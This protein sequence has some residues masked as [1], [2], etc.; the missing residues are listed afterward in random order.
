MATATA[1][2]ARGARRDY[3]R[4]RSSRKKNE[5][6]S[7]SELVGF[8]GR[9]IYQSLNDE[10]GDISSTRQENLN[11]YIGAE[12]GTERE[13]YSK[14][15]TRETL[16]TVEW[17]LPSILRVFLSGDQIVS[18]DPVL[19]EDEPAA[20]Q[21]TDI[22]NHQILKANNGQGFLALHH[23]IKDALMYPN[24]YIK[25]YVEDCVKTDVGMVTGVTEMGVQMLSDDPDVTILEQ[26]SRQ[27]LVQ[28]PP[29]P[30]MP[31][32]GGAQPVTVYDLK[33]RTTKQIR[34]LRL[35][36][37]PPEECLVDNDLTTLDLDAADFVCHRRQRSFTDLVEAGYDP[38][39]LNMV[40][41]GDNY[42]WNDERVNRLFYTDENPDSADE[43]DRGMRMFWV[44]ECYVRVDYDGDELSERRKIT[45]IGNRIFDN[46][47]TNYQ[48]MIALASILMQH[49][50]TGMSYVDIV[51][52]LQLLISILTRQVLDN[53]YKIN[54]GKKVFSEDALTEDGAT[55][56]ALL[57][58]QAEFIPVRGAA[59]M[60]FAP[61]P[62]TS[63]VGEILP[64]I[65][66]FEQQRVT[67]T[68]VTPESTLDA[69]S[70]QEV[71]QDVFANAMDRASQRIEMLVRIFAETGFRKLMLKV[72]Q[73][74]R[75]HWD[76]AKTV[77]IRGTWIDVD[78]QGWRD[79]T[80]MT[81]STGLGFATKHQTLSMLVQMLSMQKE[82]AGSGLSN[83]QKIYNALDDLVAK[84]GLGDVRNFF[85]DPS[86]P[87]Y[88]PPEPPPDPNLILAQAQ[89][90]ALQ[91][92]Q[93]RKAQEFQVTAQIDSTKAQLDA[94][95]KQADIQLKQA[96]QQ[97]KLRELALREKE[98][99][100]EGTLKEGELAARVDNILADTQLKRAQADKTMVD[101]AA[102]AV[103]ASD[104]YQQALDVVKNAGELNNGDIEGS[105]N[106]E[107]G[108]E[109][110][111]ETEGEN[112]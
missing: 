2:A 78:P 82:A 58:P 63:I 92:E 20:K 14:F 33:I 8:L 66:H 67:R 36:P 44:H 10:D 109:T 28:M 1:R 53:I 86:G 71:R 55:M 60:A 50:H 105:D 68:G 97:I 93:Q 4:K 15:V 26:D 18:F 27:V 43:D 85:V 87:E 13:G 37:V 65:Q 103:E 81:V 75:S 30:N 12:Y 51:K 111:E 11:Y 95:N 31:T 29:N 73:L 108:E 69:N 5:S 64:V 3:N 35:E 39:E 7:D 80:D 48:P 46:E 40:G 91:Q 76:I 24:G 110:D 52:D 77:K 94:Q 61:E 9:K 62:I 70:L 57:N 21:E 90:Q 54:V 23:W 88:Q 83:P 56:E 17:V 45:M 100:A 32:Q 74:L 84:S 101:A 19:P 106:S 112:D 79:R 22:A 102:T 59:Q 34:E 49:K 42:Q 6:M 41:Q 47:E 99:I 16:E 89:A 98:M 72:H 107:A 38:D 25:A 104:A 96:D